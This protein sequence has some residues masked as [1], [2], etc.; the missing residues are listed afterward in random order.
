MLSSLLLEEGRDDE[1]ISVLSPPVE[2]GIRAFVKL[3]RYLC[4]VLVS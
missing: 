2:S 3:I 4:A 1:A